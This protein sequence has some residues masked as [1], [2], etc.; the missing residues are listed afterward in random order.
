MR[1]WTWQGAKHSLTTGTIKHSESV[2]YNAES[3]LGMRAAS[4]KLWNRLGTDQIIWC[5]VGD[6]NSWCVFDCDPRMVLWE[7]DVPDAGILKFIDAS[8]WD[9]FVSD[10]DP[11][12]QMRWDTLFLRGITPNACVLLRHPIP[13]EWVVRRRKV[14]QVTAQGQAISKQEWKELAPGKNG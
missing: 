5:G 6:P 1:L 7:L 13:I 10:Q 9:R 11:V 2:D 12:P 8:L 14:T 4:E 3:L